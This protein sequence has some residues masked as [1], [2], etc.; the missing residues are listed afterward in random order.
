MKPRIV[1]KGEFWNIPSFE[2]SA[3]FL[4]FKQAYERMEHMNFLKL[5]AYFA[6]PS[7]QAGSLN[8]ETS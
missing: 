3:D 4:R 6:G 7:K 1:G 5:K 8:L 2:K